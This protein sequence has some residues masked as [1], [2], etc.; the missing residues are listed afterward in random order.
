[1][2]YSFETFKKEHLRYAWLSGK[3]TE[4]EL[5]EKYYEQYKEFCISHNLEYETR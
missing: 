4:K 2:K 1:M 5:R 3:Y